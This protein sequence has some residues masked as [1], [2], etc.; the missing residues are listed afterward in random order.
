MYP[1][2]VQIALTAVDA[3][4]VTYRGDLV[5]ARDLMEIPL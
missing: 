3:V 4:R 1:Q 2:L 5:V